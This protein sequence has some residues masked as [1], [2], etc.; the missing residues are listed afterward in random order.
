[1]NEMIF[2]VEEATEGGFIAR[3]LG[4][5]IHTDANELTDLHTNV[6]DAVMCHFEPTEKPRIIR[7][8]LL[9]DN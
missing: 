3:A 4:H 8:R 1:M 9:G 2:L 5:S 6:R 7:F